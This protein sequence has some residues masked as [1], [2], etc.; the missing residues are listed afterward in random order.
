MARRSINHVGF[1]LDE[2]GSM[3][4]RREETIKAVNEY[5]QSLRRDKAFITFATFDSEQGVNFRNT[6]TKA[7]QIPD[8]TL[9]TYKPNASTPLYDAVGKMVSTMFEQATTKDKVVIIV[10]TDGQ[11]NASRE[12]TLD[13]VKELIKEYEGKQWVFAYVGAAPDAWDGAGAMGLPTADV[14]N[15]SGGQ[16]MMMASM[17]ANAVASAD[18]FSGRVTHKTFYRNARH[19]VEEKEKELTSKKR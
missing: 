18:Y 1:L 17:A 16:G 15:T 19:I 14:L 6:A 3:G 5:F 9:E 12:F 7:A 2:T 10:V 13:K 11:E 4:V 8:L